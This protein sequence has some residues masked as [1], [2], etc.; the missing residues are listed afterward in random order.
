L[1]LHPERPTKRIAREKIAPEKSI[2]RLALRKE[3]A[4]EKEGQTRKEEEFMSANPMVGG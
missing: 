3:G 2:P 4:E 1:D